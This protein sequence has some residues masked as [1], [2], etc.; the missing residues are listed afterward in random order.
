MC[1]APPERTAG[2]KRQQ[3][4]TNRTCARR[5]VALTQG[6]PELRF[7]TGKTLAPIFTKRIGP[8]SGQSY[9]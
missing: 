8:Q 9:W 1:A 7:N 6:Q 4:G 3:S 5:D 2:G